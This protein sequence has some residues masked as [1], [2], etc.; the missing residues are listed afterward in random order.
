[1]ARRCTL[2]AIAA[3]NN[4]AETSF[5]VK[6]GDGLNLRWFT[7]TTEVDLCGHA[8]LAAAFVLMT[9]LDQKR[10]TVRF[11]SKSGPLHVRRDHRDGKVFTLDFPKRDATVTEVP[12]ALSQALGS[13][14]VQALSGVTWMAVLANA[15]AV[16]A[17]RPNIAAIAALGKDVIITAPGSGTD[18][19]V[20]F[21]SRYFAPGHGIDEDPVT[22]SAHC[23]L[24]PYWA[25]RLGKLDLKARQVS[26]R[27]GELG[28]AVKRRSRAH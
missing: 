28:V 25:Q 3:E 18:A 10:V 24:G 8:T 23:M 22:G 6:S 16:H 17:L 13:K 1:M 19:D 9:E 11:E 2:Q 20:D 4:L 26:K 7:P 12:A 15:E 14:P 27:R 5:F 21:V